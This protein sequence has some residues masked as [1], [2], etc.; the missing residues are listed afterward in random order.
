MGIQAFMAHQELATDS[1]SLFIEMQ[2][3]KFLTTE[4]ILQT[5]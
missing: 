1:L 5:R 4:S 2:M 3:G